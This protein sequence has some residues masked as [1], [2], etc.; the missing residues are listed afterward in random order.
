MSEG[1]GVRGHSF[2]LVAVLQGLALE[3]DWDQIQGRMLDG[4][5]WAGHWVGCGGAGDCARKDRSRGAP[6]LATAG[7]YRASA[8]G[9]SGSEPAG[10][11]TV[12]PARPSAQV[13]ETGEPTEAA[14]RVAAATAEL[15]KPD[16]TGIPHEQCPK[17]SES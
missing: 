15:V 11:F 5:R 7:H 2:Q 1:I 16:W 8:R 10:P 13:R 3:S 4:C 14:A 12:Q 17:S 9:A 6:K